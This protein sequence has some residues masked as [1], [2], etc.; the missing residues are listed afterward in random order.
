MNIIESNLQFNG[1]SWGNNPKMIVLHHAE[2][3]TCSIQDIHQW[4][5]NNGWAGCGY[6]FLVR[7][8][9][10]VYRGRP[11]EAIGSHCHGVNATSLGVCAEGDFT[12][13]SMPDVQKN[14]IVELCKY[15]CSKYGISSIKGHKELYSTEC[16]GT[17]YPLQQIRELAGTSG[18]V[19]VVATNTSILKLWSSG[20]AVKDLQE[21][22][23]KLGYEIYGGADGIFGQATYNAV[24]LFQASRKLTPDGIAG[25]QTMLSLDMAIANKDAI[26]IHSIKYLQ[27][28]IGVAED[29]IPG[30]ATLSKCPILKIGCNS[31]TVKWA[32]AKLNI[33]AD[34][35]FGNGTKIAVQNYQAAHGLSADGIVG[36]NTWKKLLGL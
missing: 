2:A 26:D 24:E 5:L 14:A 30:P 22:L 17:N 31:N 12:K 34:G 36:Q 28:E 10:S 16:P 11:E 35:I 9:G 33:A 8:D 6:H 7:K 4:H 19:N 21:K 32:Q 18:S 20:S 1:L 25:P 13:E 29:N 23:I 15:L 27:H 3:S